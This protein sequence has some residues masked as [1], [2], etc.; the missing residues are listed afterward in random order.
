MKTI[1]DVRTW[2]TR[3]EQAIEDPQFLEQLREMQII[4][5]NIERD[6]NDLF[7]ERNKFI[8]KNVELRKEIKIL[9]DRLK[10]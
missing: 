2:L 7:E 4:T 8:S 5:H 9:Q 3:L 10:L 1:K 6:L